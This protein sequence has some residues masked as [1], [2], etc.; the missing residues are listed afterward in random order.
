M[1]ENETQVQDNLRNVLN[2]YNTAGV[3][4]EAVILENIAFFALDYE[5]RKIT[6]GMQ[7]TPLGELARHSGQG[8]LQKLLLTEVI[9]LFNEYEVYNKEQLVL[10]LLPSPPEDVIVK[11]IDEIIYLL[12]DM[13]D[14]V[15]DLGK[16]FDQVL[17][18]RLFSISK[19]GRYATPRHLIDFMAGVVNLTPDDR[20]ADFACGTGGMLVDS[21]SLYPWSKGKVTGIEISPNMARLAFTNLVLNQQMK[22]ELYLGN[23]FDVAAKEGSF[24]D[25]KFDAIMMNPP[26]GASIEPFL[27]WQTFGGRITGRSE[28]LFASL[29]YEKLKPGGRM[30]V[31]VPSGVL[32]STGSG[33][34]I[35][36]EMLVED[37]ALQAVISLPRDSMQPVNSLDTHVLYAVNSKEKDLVSGIWFYRPRYDGFMGKRNREPSPINDLHLVKEACGISMDNLDAVQA[38]PLKVENKV[39]GYQVASEGTKNFVVHK[40]GDGFLIEVLENGV[41]TEFIK[42]NGET[43][44]RGKSNLVSLSSKLQPDKEISGKFKAQS[45]SEHSLESSPE[46]FFSLD[47]GKGELRSKSRSISK[48]EGQIDTIGI[49]I[50]QYGAIASRPFPLM[51]DKSL[52]DEESHVYV[53]YEEDRKELTAYLIFFQSEINGFLLEDKNGRQTYL[54]NWTKENGVAQIFFPDINVLVFLPPSRI[55]GPKTATSSPQIFASDQV[56]RGILFTKHSIALG[57]YISRQEIL[58]SKNTELQPEKYWVKKSQVE[59]TRSTAQILGAIKK[60]QNSLTGILDQLLSISEIQALAGSELPPRLKMSEYP[61]ENLKGVQQSIWKVVQTRTEQLNGYATPKPF[62]PD[63]IKELLTEN[64]SVKDIQSTLELFERMGLIVA[65]SYEGAPYFRLPEERD[66]VAEQE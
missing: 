46:E 34:T 58:K 51:M 62:Q 8:A 14:K 13:F 64:V 39:E 36:R 44:F 16:W 30:A 9:Q 11:R 41:T 55:T 52:A 48:P 60:N 32:F 49:L 59:T 61:A 40:L 18:P 5:C 53:L 20:L 63:D 50:N 42:M 25:S 26:F 17:I 3:L 27:I 2:I 22:H 6:R 29:A 7:F 21:H 56:H 35:F 23:A 66:W 12:H 65:V 4:D 10:S 31:L 47:H 45:F 33:E 24:I 38:F 1:S 37:G 19:G 15:G 54:C 43:V 57:Y 28:T